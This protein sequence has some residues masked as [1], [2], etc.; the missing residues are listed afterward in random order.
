MSFSQW[1]EVDS[2]CALDRLFVQRKKQQLHD[3]IDVS[4]HE[5]INRESGNGQAVCDL[6]P[7]KL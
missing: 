1:F 4:L 3:L 2:L 6:H 7:K 5:G